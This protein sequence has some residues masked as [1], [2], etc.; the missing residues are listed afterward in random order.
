MK[1]KVVLSVFLIGLSMA[2]GA[3]Y[4]VFVYAKNHHRSVADE[5]GI[6]ISAGNIVKEYQA[7]E[8]ASNTKYLNKALQIS[9]VVSEVKKDQIGNTTV[10]IKSDDPFASVFCTLANK[11]AV[12]PAVGKNV[13]V[14]GICTGFLSDVV[15]ADA[16]LVP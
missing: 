3:W 16:V 9:G 14:K 5:T 10:T 7:N 15:I 4:Y 1:I 2:A 11:E 12:V 6:V 13:S 8:S